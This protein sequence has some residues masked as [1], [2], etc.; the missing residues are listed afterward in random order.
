MKRLMNRQP[1]N[2]FRYVLGALPFILVFVF[3]VFSSNTRLAENPNDKFLPSLET[4]AKSVKVMTMEPSKRSGEYI[5]WNDTASSL[6]RLALGVGFAATIGLIFGIIN[7]VVPLLRANLSPFITAFSLVPPLA[8]LPIL[9]I[10]F[11]LGEFS[12]VM[13]IAIGITPFIIRDLQSKVLELPREQMIKAQTLGASTWLVIVRVV[14]PQILPRLIE[15][16]R[17]SLGA[18]WLFLIAA[19]AIASTDGLGYRIFLVRR[20]MSMDVILPYV[21]WITLLAFLTDYVLR[22]ISAKSF[23]WFHSMSK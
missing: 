14:L 18:A 7:G 16:V 4:M 17:M 1:D 21:I 3:Y 6:Q 13:L 22:L 8:V 15:A 23:P 12:K 20:Y 11:G 19:E 9:F 5:L 10:V 2:Y